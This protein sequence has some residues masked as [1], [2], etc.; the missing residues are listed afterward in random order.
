MGEPLR[1]WKKI[2][3][4][5]RLR[6]VLM[7]RSTTVLAATKVAQAIL[8][9]AATTKVTLATLDPA[10][11]VLAAATKVDPVTPTILV[12]QA[13]QA[14]LEATK[15]A[16]AQDPVVPLAAIRTIPKNPKI[17]TKSNTSSSTTQETRRSTKFKSNIRSATAP[18]SN[19]PV[20]TRPTTTT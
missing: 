7:K 13:T 17:L 2:I 9:L 3:R 4:S 18:A 14:T 6:R 19:T 1:A 12:V 16:V 10:T 15:V 20:A 8:V 5:H 11:L